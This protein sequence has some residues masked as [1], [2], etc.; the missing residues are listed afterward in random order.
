MILYQLIGDKQIQIQL[1][2]NTTILKIKTS[3]V[4]V[5]PYLVKICLEFKFKEYA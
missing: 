4:S 2:V 5:L 1:D 3:K